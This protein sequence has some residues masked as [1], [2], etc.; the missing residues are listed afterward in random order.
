MRIHEVIVLLRKFYS[1][2][3]NKMEA[4]ARIELVKIIKEVEHERTPRTN[5]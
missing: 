5:G 4:E 2:Y 1:K 3:H